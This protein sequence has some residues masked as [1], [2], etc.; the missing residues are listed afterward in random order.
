VV[1]IHFDDL[2]DSFDLTLVIRLSSDSLG[3]RVSPVLFGLT[4]FPAVGVYAV[5][6]VV[7]SFDTALFLG[8]FCDF[9]WDWT[10]V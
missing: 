10:V 8:V 9:F 1:H 6:V 7:A 4:V 5:T 2:F 3:L